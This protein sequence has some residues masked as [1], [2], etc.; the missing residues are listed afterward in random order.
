MKRTVLCF[1][2]LAA[3]AASLLSGA[4]SAEYRCANPQLPADIRACALARQGPDQLRRFVE[5]TRAI[6][7]LNFYDYVSDEDFA[8]W[9]A[10]RD[11]ADRLA[12]NQADGRAE[13]VTTE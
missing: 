7:Q 12:R 13:N 4:V 8:R 10:E 1:T 9:D 2:G 6:Y 5:S 11:A 3:A